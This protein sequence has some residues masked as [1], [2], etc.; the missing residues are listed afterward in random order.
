MLKDHSQNCL[1]WNILTPSKNFK[2]KRM[3]PASQ[4]LQPNIRG[5]PTIPVAESEQSPEDR[6]QNQVESLHKIVVAVI[7][8]VDQDV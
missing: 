2:M 3:P 4:A 1:V 5:W 6:F 7:A 8:A